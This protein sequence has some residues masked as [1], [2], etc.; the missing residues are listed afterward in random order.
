MK[1]RI[2]ADTPMGGVVL[3]INATPDLPDALVADLVAQGVADPDPAA[4]AYAETLGIE[5]PALSDE[6][7]AAYVAP[8]AATKDPKL[9]GA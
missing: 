4:V 9:K 7:L 6:M 8:P 3:P 2:L 1:V 5:A